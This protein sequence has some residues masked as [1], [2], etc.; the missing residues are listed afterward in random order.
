MAASPAFIV[1]APLEARSCTV[2][3]FF[4]AVFRDFA[5]FRDFAVFPAFAAFAFFFFALAMC[6]PAP[7]FPYEALFL[8]TALTLL[9]RRPYSP[10]SRI[11][12]TSQQAGPVSGRRPS[13]C[14]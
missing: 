12:S 7:S 1:L 9:L 2:T 3:D 8:H 13:A 5:A 14:A 10:A 4:F 11:A 6:P